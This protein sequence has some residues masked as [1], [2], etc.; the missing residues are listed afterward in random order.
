MFHEDFIFSRSAN[1]NCIVLWAIVGFSSANDPPRPDEAP[2][3]HDPSQSTL[4]YFKPT[5]SSQAYMRLIEF[6]APETE[7]LTM[8]FSI[9]PGLPNSTAHH[10]ILACGN[11]YSKIYFWDL[12]RLEEYSDYRS[13]LPVQ[14]THPHPSQP[15]IEFTSTPT[16]S[17]AIAS[18]S[19]ESPNQPYTHSQ[20]KRPPFLHTTRARIPRSSSNS[21]SNSHSN[22]RSK[23]DHHK[24]ASNP[25]PVTRI[26][27][28]Q[29]PS[30]S[31]TTSTSNS[32]SHLSQP[33]LPLSHNPQPQPYP[34]YPFPFTTHPT[35]ISDIRTWDKKY[36]LGR[37]LQR[38][39]PHKEEVVKGLNFLGRQTA[40]SRGGEWCVV[41]GSMR[42]VG[43]LGR[44]EEGGEEKEREKERGRGRGRGRGVS[45]LG[46]ALGL[47]ARREREMSELDMDVE[48]EGEEEAD[49]E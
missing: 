22:S 25:N 12:S 14:L 41:V 34:A 16:A 15:Q 13:A 19:S 1:E 44:W 26:L 33:A 6:S 10:P 8:R 42:C 18:F 27:R 49:S 24:D 37:P 32:S 30:A 40:W 23:R 4:S 3:S 2:T 9:F 35:T 43:V 48:T 7:I 29:S 38:L 11:S 5:T 21:T 28:D 46:L 45:G 31:S 20:P 39:L 17:S 47:R 36:L